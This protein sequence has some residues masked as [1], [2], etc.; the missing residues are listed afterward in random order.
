[1]PRTHSDEQDAHQHLA[2][3]ISTRNV[4]LGANVHYTGKSTVTP[5]ACALGWDGWFDHTPTVPD[6]S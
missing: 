6:L 1:M 5:N 2:T 3:N 4:Y